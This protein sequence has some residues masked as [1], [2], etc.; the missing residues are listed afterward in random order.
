MVQ[1]GQ[2]LFGGICSEKGKFM[3]FGKKVF[4]SMM[5]KGY[6]LI[7]VIVLILPTLVHAQ[8]NDVPPTFILEG[9][10]ASRTGLS[11]AKNTCALV[12]VRDLEAVIESIKRETPVF[13]ACEVVT[14]AFD[15]MS[16][17]STSKVDAICYQ[18]PGP[19]L[20][21]SH[22]TFCITQDAVYKIKQPRETRRYTMSISRIPRT[23]ELDQELQ[24]F[25]TTPRPVLK[26]RGFLSFDG[27]Y[28]FYVRR[29][30]DHAFTCT[31]F[32]YLPEDSRPYLPKEN[33][34][35]H[36]RSRLEE[37]M[38]KPVVWSDGSVSPTWP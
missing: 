17:L 2:R 18:S 22:V 20:G 38:V 24:L 33:A 26:N 4:V 21:M 8:S 6:E 36:L 30:S 7:V 16:L 3:N 10:Y 15:V 5:K 11:V 37:L 35:L 19:V 14:F 27:T 25:E 9:G 13:S 31:F 1:V 34:F 23:E 28:G 12:N 29:R 32:K